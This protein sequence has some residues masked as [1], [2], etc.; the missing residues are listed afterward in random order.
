MIARGLL[1]LAV[2]AVGGLVGMFVAR[3]AGYVVVAYDGWAVETSLW[4][5]LAAFLVGY[6]LVWGSW[7]LLR[8][9]LESQ[10]KI[11]RWRRGRQARK[12][13]HRTV[14]GLLLLAEGRW[15]DA[16]KILVA[17]ADQVELPF[18]NY[19]NAARAAHEL[20]DAE[21]R[22]RYLRRVYETTPG[23]K[24]SATLLQSEFRIQDGAHDQALASLL[25]LRKR[26]PKH[27]AV[28]RMLAQCY[29]ALEDWQA[30]HA[31]LKDL[32]A[33]KVVDD[34]EMKR[35]S[36]LVWLSIVDAE[37]DP[38]SARPAGVNGLWKRMP[39]IVKA[40]RE[41][42]RRWITA[43][44]SGP[45]QDGAEQ[46][47]RLI[48]ARAWDDEFAALYGDVHTT[49]LDQQVAHAQRWLKERPD[50]VVVLTVLGKLCQ[51][52]GQ[53][54]TARTHFEAA[55]RLAPDKTL[56]GALGRLCIALGDEKRGTDY[57]LKS[58]GELPAP[59]QLGVGQ[60]AT[61]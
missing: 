53:Y 3:D 21:G 40:D 30:L 33:H 45:S 22:D 23:A 1:F 51:A 50:D 47:L 9:L 41:V 59:M 56:Y 35:L 60:P 19:L 29:E 39:N 17:A 49:A 43:L 27:K 44:R 14:R 25:T 28:L 5:A 16:K 38:D 13:R 57:L 42:L 10:G 2:V 36:R 20:G 12:A 37:G 15:E 18:T 46:A 26:A 55:L 52:Q 48:L 34:A 54:E 11:S 24:F 32:S 58:V 4:V 61:A 7:V 31:H 6:L 8:S